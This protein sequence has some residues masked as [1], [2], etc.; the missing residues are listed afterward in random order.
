M[1]FLCEERYKMEF[2]IKNVGVVKDSIIKLDGLTVITGLNNSGKST[3]GKA[4]YS[5]NEAFSD[6]ETKKEKQ[7]S[8]ILVRCV[9]EIQRILNLDEVYKY[10]NLDS[11][12]GKYRIFFDGFATGRIRLTMHR[13]SDSEK[14]KDYFSNL[15]LFLDILSSDYLYSIAIKTK[16]DL[17]KKFINYANNFDLAVEK[18]KIVISERMELFEDTNNIQFSKIAVSNLL[19]EEFKGQIYPIRGRDKDRLS[20]FT[21]KKNDEIAFEF[22]FSDK[23]GVTNVGKIFNKLFYNNTILIDDAYVLDNNSNS[24]YFPYYL[25]DDN[26]FDYTHKSTLLKMIANQQGGS[27]LENFL[28]DK[29]YEEIR[30]EIDSVLPGNI[31]VKDGDYFYKSEE[32]LEPIRFENL[33]TGSKLFAILKALLK[34]GKINYDT[35]LILDEPEAHLHP[36]WQNIMA[37]LIVL[38]VKKLNVNVLL[39]THSINFVLAI[40]TFMHKYSISKLTNFYKTEWLDSDHY[41]VNYE[42]KNNSLDEIYEKLNYS[43]DEMTLKKNNLI[44]N[45]E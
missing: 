17:P 15:K 1:L 7:L 5:T 20:K 31:I 29:L 45:K 14:I 32:T 19:M 35:M 24:R 39:T 16:G 13:K 3:I 22:T 27:A 18:A 37:E 26:S 38:L 30:E 11:V 40:E 4:L 43:F 44:D 10:I 6:I 33:A 28:N 23:T 2:R 8:R 25:T 34:N 41:F 36:E 42:C 9:M 12:D 21:L